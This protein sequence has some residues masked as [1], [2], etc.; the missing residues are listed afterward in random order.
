M[1]IGT[2]ENFW[3]AFALSGNPM[4]YLDYTR[5]RQKNKKERTSEN[6]K[7]TRIGN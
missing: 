6:N 3:Q 5:S 4:A 7:S 2:S 1:E